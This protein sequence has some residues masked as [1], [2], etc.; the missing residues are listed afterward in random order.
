[1]N[2]Q[3]GLICAYLFDGKGGA[4][5]IDWDDISKW[6]PQEGTIWIHLERDDPESMRWIK[7]KSNIDPLIAEALLAEET[8]PRSMALQ[9]GLLVI[10]R[11]VNMNPGSD[12]EDMISIRMWLENNR[13]ISLRKLKLMAINDIR[14]KLAKN[15]G[16]TGSGHFLVQLSNR[17]IERMGTVI[18]DIEEEVDSLEEEVLEAPSN[19]IR[20]KLSDLR[21]KAIR[22]RRFLSPQRDV[23]SYLQSERL[24]WLSDMN[25]SQLREVGDKLL[26]YIENLDEIRD[27]AAVTQEELAG[28]I[29]DQMNKTMYILG[30]V[31]T[32]FLPLGLLTGLLGINVAGIPGTNNNYAFI[33]VCIIL[34]IIAIFEFIAFKR[35]RLL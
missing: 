1:M 6:I 34:I 25:R 24:S 20:S 26:R 11:G 29:S 33:T 28:R 7:E 2:E 12:P 19:E 21:R 13:I 10:L 5:Q 17:L 22:L 3:D 23:M 31:A 18:E 4:R 14:D 15:E 35:K 9:D 30:L 27:R 16:P 8:R 32:I